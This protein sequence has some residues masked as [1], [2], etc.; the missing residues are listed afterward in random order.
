MTLHDNYKSCFDWIVG[1]SHLC[2]N[3]EENKEHFRHILLFYFRRGK[4]AAEAGREICTVYGTDA[5]NE[6]TC[7]KW[8]QRFRSGDFNLEDAPRSGRPITIDDDQI[9]SLVQKDRQLTTQE[10]ADTLEIDR[11]TVAK[12]LKKL[13]MM[14]KADAWVPCE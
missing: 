10:I 3:M 12:R 8:F 14:K 9:L 13:G 5:I 4:K 1:A 11:T 7:Q 6:K 2:L